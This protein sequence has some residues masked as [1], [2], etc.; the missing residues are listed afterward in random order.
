[1]R[2]KNKINPERKVKPRYAER[3]KKKR[4]RKKCSGKSMSTQDKNGKLT[5]T[6]M[7]ERSFVFRRKKRGGKS[8]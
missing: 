2:A 4:K 8:S 6:E 3:E 1:V 5:P 7:E